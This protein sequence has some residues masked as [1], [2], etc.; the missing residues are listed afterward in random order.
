[1][2]IAGNPGFSQSMDPFMPTVN[3]REAEW[4]EEAQS[5]DQDDLENAIAGLIQ[6]DIAGGSAALYFTLGNLYYQAEMYEEAVTAYEAALEKFPTFRNAKINLGRIYLVLER[7][8]E[9]I[10]LYQE[11]VRDGVADAETYLLLGHALMME[12]YPVSAEN[13]YRQALLLDQTSKEA[14]RG[15][16][17]TLLSQ[18]R[19]REGLALAKE[20]LVQDPDQREYWAARANAQLSLGQ[21]EG[22]MGSLE[23]ARRLGRAD[24][25]M[26]ATLGELYL[27]QEIPAEAAARFA[28]AFELG[29]DRLQ[30]RERAITGLLQMGAMEEAERLLEEFKNRLDVVPDTEKPEWDLS[31]LRLR[32]RLDL[33]QGKWEE[34]QEKGKQILERDPMDGATLLMLA[35]IYEEQGDVEQA[36]SYC[37]RAAR[38]TGFVAAALIQ[39]ALLEVGRQ[40]V[41]TGI[42]LLE[43]AQAYEEHAGVARYLR[44]LRRVGD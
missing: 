23:Q 9:A 35:R 13:A 24:A 6:R 2:M 21:M 31:Y 36:V 25:D 11:L 20:L 38:I 12:S 44:Q 7:E 42:R 1:M 16:L 8:K 39:Q 18:E 40:R 10:R 37:E 34:A 33:E 28:E 5:G 15:L 43:R 14:R 22:A 19:Y 3:R 32:S 41:E 27:Q 30:R 4:I 17:R 26:L 29:E